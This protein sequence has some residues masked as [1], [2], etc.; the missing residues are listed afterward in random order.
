M[1]KNNE[2]GFTLAESLLSLMVL[3]TLAVFLL[4]LM[5]QMTG[6]SKALWE[7]QK[8]MRILY[9]E[10][11]KRLLEGKNFHFTYHGEGE[12]YDISWETSEA[13]VCYEFSGQAAC[14]KKQ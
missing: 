2:K 11:E 7:K 13:T 3:V 14:I 12:R 1:L 10:G 8:G 5:M 9:E 4:P 6:Q